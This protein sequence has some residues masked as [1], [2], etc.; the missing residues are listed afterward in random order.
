MWWGKT[1]IILPSLSLVLSIICFMYF[2]INRNQIRLFFKMRIFWDSHDGL[3]QCT[4]SLTSFYLYM[5]YYSIYQF[6]SVYSCSNCQEHKGLRKHFKTLQVFIWGVL[7]LHYRPHF[8]D[9][10]PLRI[11]FK[12]KSKMQNFQPSHWSCSPELWSF[13]WSLF[14]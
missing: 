10:T 6:M 7:V 9:H 5:N 3:K 12:L 11:L 8:T 4:T 14:Y 1:W 13:F 2:I